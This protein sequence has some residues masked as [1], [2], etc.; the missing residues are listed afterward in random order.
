MPAGAAG[1]RTFRSVSGSGRMLCPTA[2]RRIA[3]LLDK[4]NGPRWGRLPLLAKA[5][6]RDEIGVARLVLAA[7][8]IQQRTALVDEH[9]EAA[10]RVIVLRV[11]LEVHRQVVDALG[12]DRDLNLRRSGVALAL[13]VLLAE[14]FLAL[15][16]SRQRLTPPS[17]KG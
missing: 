7:Q 3:G 13:R 15:H 16:C 17:S 10:S 4:R 2:P 14:R 12:E 9:Q 11:G 6:L 8:I 1:G 5:E